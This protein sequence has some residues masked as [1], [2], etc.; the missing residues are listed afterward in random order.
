M[1]FSVPTS[2]APVTLVTAEEDPIVE[3]LDNGAE[4]TG[5]DADDI[6]L[7]FDIGAVVLS[8]SFVTRTDDDCWDGR[9][10]DFI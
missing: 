8:T 6:M 9:G 10:T 1:I 7:F 2:G 3:E 5:V 4:L